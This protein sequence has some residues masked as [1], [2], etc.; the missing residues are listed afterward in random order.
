M[1]Q[2]QYG[3]G[4]ITEKILSECMSSQVWV[5]SFF[6][7]ST[8]IAKGQSHIDSNIFSHEKI[9]QERLVIAYF[10]SENGRES[11]KHE[12]NWG[13]K[14]FV[15]ILFFLNWQNI[16]HNIRSEGKYLFRL[17]DNI[18]SHYQVKFELLHPSNIVWNWPKENTLDM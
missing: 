17:S 6:L 2:F 12:Q 3:Q 13:L 14:E 5:K 10:L 1:S 18:F 15:K 9:T 8:I 4:C 7:F 16:P 11:C